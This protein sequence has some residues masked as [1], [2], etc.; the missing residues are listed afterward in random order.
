MFTQG[1]IHLAI[2]AYFLVPSGHGSKFDVH[3]G[4]KAAAKVEETVILRESTLSENLGL[5]TVIRPDQ[6]IAALQSS[7]SHLEAV[8]GWGEK[9][10]EPAPEKFPF[11]KY[12]K[13]MKEKFVLIWDEDKGIYF[14]GTYYPSAC[15]DP[16]MAC[17]HMQ[18][19]V[20]CVLLTPAKRGTFKPDSRGKT[21]NDFFDYPDSPRIE[22]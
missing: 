3:A 10:K 18:A 1:M 2:L 12:S 6:E 21:P 16:F 7:A 19:P 9:I 13:E 15:D 17:G 14:D 8:L 11:A 4:K 5:E 20:A 22:R